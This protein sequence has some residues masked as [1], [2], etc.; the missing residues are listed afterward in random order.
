MGVGGAER[1]LS[2]LCQQLLR[3][4]HDVSVLLYY[5]GGALEDELREAGI[6]IIDLKK[7]GRWRNLDFLRR[8]VHAVRAEQPDV[9]YA[10]LTVSNLLAL[11]IRPLVRGCTIAC[12]VRSTDM[13]L[14][15]LDRLAWLT[16]KL[17]RRLA[18]HA[19]CVIVNSQSG[20]RYLCG[21]RP[22][23]N[24][25]VVEN[26]IEA[27]AYA[28]EESGRR[29]MRTAWR[30]EDDT[31]VIGCVARLDPIKDHRTLLHAFALLRRSR[32]DARL[33]C[34]G[35][36]TGP[37]AAALRALARDLQVD[38]AIQW[39]EREPRLRELYSALDVAC[40]TSL[41]EGFPNVLAEA[42]ASGV[43][44][45]STDVGDAGRILSCFDYLVPVGDPR[46]LAQAL[47]DAL[48]QGRVHGQQRAERIG[49]EFSPESM[50]DKTERALMAAL[51]RRN[52]RLA[53]AT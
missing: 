8:L 45:V 20:E 30:L 5:A 25:V 50:A 37:C 21:D 9:L 12:G 36:G 33:I 17:E 15:R 11:L 41:S 42:M 38:A 19:D 22:S 14:G 13:T 35:G 29:R 51:E 48:A 6:P 1:Q 47:G 34:V 2:L 4:G 24:V 32:P 26:G 44:C 3:R 46:R 28:F 16:A 10:W 27:R 7:R 18:R 31:P 40:L 53:K 52:A 43:P 49:R 39:I 23:Q